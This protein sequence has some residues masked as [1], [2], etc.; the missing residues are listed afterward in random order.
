MNE[1]TRFAV[2]VTDKLECCRATTGR[3][4]VMKRNMVLVSNIA[5]IHQRSHATTNECVAAASVFCFKYED[6]ILLNHLD[7][8]WPHGT[9]SVVWP[10]NSSFI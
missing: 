10:H 3:V 7:S 5:T 4:S 6:S 8:L 1:E 2:S 9:Q